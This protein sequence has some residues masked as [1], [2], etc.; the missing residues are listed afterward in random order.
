M[1]GLQIN[2]RRVKCTSL[3]DKV[4]YLFECSA[5]HQRDSLFWVNRGRVVGRD[6]NRRQG[7]VV[8]REGATGGG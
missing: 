5:Y 8:R 4:R 2:V 3:F 6:V 1:T 7:V